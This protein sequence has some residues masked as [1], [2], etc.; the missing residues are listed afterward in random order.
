MKIVFIGGSG[1]L[2]MPVA[3]QLIS[4]GFDLTLLARDPDRMHKLFPGS[5]V[6]QGDVLDKKSLLTAFENCDAVYLNLS[7]SQTSREKD[8]QPER[9]G[10]QNVIQ[11]AQQ[12]NV[13][14][15]AYLSSLIHNYQGMNGFHWWAFDIKQKSVAAVK[16]SGIAYTIFYPSTFM[17][18]LSHQMRKGNRLFLLGKSEAS[19]WW[20]ASRDYA[21][22]VSRSFQKI[23]N[24]NKEYVVQ[25]LEAYDFEEAAQ[26]FVDNYSKKKLSVMKMPMGFVKFFGNFSQIMDYGARICEALNK[27]PEKFESE[28]TWAELGKPTTTLKQF[29]QTI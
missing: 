8:L 10:I 9:E 4:D 22:Q 12:K 18:T 3:K 7:I 20:I 26:I 14:R 28:N 23:E 27:Y 13:K 2:G 29:S 24:E 16:S 1:M 25:G 21:T 6:I 19:M 5:K 11:A 15:I 17:E